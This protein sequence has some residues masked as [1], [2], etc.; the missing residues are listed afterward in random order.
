M[1]LKRMLALLG[2]GLL[3]VVG[4]GLYVVLVEMRPPPD[5]AAATRGLA[6]PYAEAAGRSLAEA[7]SKLEV[8]RG[9][10][11]LVVERVAGQAWR[12]TEPL[13]ARADRS[14]VL[15]ILTDIGNLRVESTVP[16]K[17]L[18]DFGLA[19][20]RLRA[21]FWLAGQRRD[22]AIG[23]EVRG[24]KP[25]ERK[26]YLRVADSRSV[27]VV[28][29]ALA[30]KLDRPPEAFRDRRVFDRARSPERAKTVRIL[31]AE[32]KLVVERAEDGWR[33]ASPVAD[34]A[35]R[36]SVGALLLRAARLEAVAY[37]TD[38]AG[39]GAYGLDEPAVTCEL[40]TEEGSAM[41]LLVDAAAGE[42]L[43]Y[44]KRGEEPAIFTIR[45]ADLSRIA[46]APDSLRLRKV[47]ELVPAELT[48]IEIARGDARWAVARPAADQPWALVAPRQAAASQEAVAGFIAA[49]ARLRVARWID[50]PWA[51]AH[52]L[53]RKPEATVTLSRGADASTSKPPI[54]LAISPAIK[55]SALDGRLVQ[56]GGQK[57]LLV[58]ASKL[59]ETLPPPEAMASAK[60]AEAIAATVARG[61]LAFL[62]RRVFHFDANQ[63]TKLEIER[64]DAMVVCE[65]AGEG[66][67]MTLPVAV[68][69]DALN[70]ASIV[71]AMAN[72]RAE[73]FVAEGPEDLMPHGLLDPARALT[74][75][76][77]E[78]GKPA[79]KKTLLVGTPVEGEV[80]AMVDGAKL[81]FALRSWDVRALSGE[82]LATALGRWAVED[83]VGL[84]FARRGEHPIVL[85]R[86]PGGW[87]LTWPRQ[88]AASGAGVAKL[89]GALR[90]FEIPRYLDY[91][92]AGPAGYYGLDAPAA[93]LTVSVRGGAD[94]V[95]EVGRAV[96]EGA[97]VPGYAARL[98]G[99]RQVFLMPKTTVDALA[100]AFG[101]LASP[102]RP[103]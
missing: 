69:A 19:E 43:L 45:E 99:R 12:L 21:A 40:A 56:R 93:T 29:A 68:E 42:G 73:T 57:C 11:R 80:R 50:D 85:E 16:A 38:P 20:P 18:A 87:R 92:G 74:V 55:T 84:S 25:Q 53:F 96:A 4:L 9:G 37:V 41:T 10:Q 23:D 103:D 5:P 60:A 6:F 71:G 13:D 70:V 39:L 59:V 58:V 81:V 90:D 52:E 28:D 17:D 26:T 33:L 65:R 91:E 27:H 77:A 46:V 30:G 54:T 88:A 89:L 66:W 36:G 63:V 35:D 64:D 83:V 101:R 86:A 32:R 102:A 76:V 78:P 47:V 94:V 31:T 75:T 3:L 22:F 1:G 51:T 61:H 79:R 8:R 34:L 62:D 97:G 44:A 2:I 98:R 72:L 95:I 15:A 49:L 7:A 14:A 67:R 48:S 100:E 24:A 82:P